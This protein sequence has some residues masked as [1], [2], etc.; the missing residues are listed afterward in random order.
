MNR[1]SQQ[2]TVCVC[3]CVCARACVCVQF[4]LSVR[5]TYAKTNS[6]GPDTFVRYRKALKPQVSHHNVVT[7]TV[8][9][10]YP[11]VT[12]AED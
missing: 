8:A 6:A 2:Q 9:R 12:W 7:S 3:V 5:S 1:I 11:T 4:N 10:A